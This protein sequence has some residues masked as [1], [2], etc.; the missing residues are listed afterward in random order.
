M[1]STRNLLCIA[2]L[3]LLA[4]TSS[5]AHAQTEVRVALVIGNGAY[6]HVPALPNPRNDSQKIAQKLTAIGFQVTEQ[7]NLTNEGFRRALRDFAR[8]A[9]GADM[10]LIYFAGHGIELNKFNYLIPVDAKLATDR[11]VEFEAIS[12]DMLM[13][14]ISDAKGLKMVLLDACRNNPFAAKMKTTGA[15][16]SIGRGLA[17]VE[18]ARGTLVS[19]A[20]KE[21]TT[22]A[23]GAGDHSPYTQALLDH[24]HQPGL[25][26]NFLFRKVRDA[27]IDATNGE[28]EPFTYG[29]LPG[30][31]VFLV[32]PAA[33]ASLPNGSSSDT[34]TDSQNNGADSSSQP[35]SG[36]DAAT[37]EWRLW[38]SVRNSGNSALLREYLT[39]YPKGRYAGIARV[40]IQQMQEQQKTASDNEPANDNAVQPTSADPFP[41]EQDI[42]P[43]NSFEHLDGYDAFGNDIRRY[44][45]V[46]LETCEAR[47]RSRSDCD[48]YTYNKRHRVCF[49]KSG[50]RFV[51]PNATAFTGS[52]A[53]S[54]RRRS[55]QAYDNFDFAGGDYRSIYGRNMIEC[56][57]ECESSSQC[58]G[59]AYVYKNKS[60][61]LKSHVGNFRRKRGVSLYVK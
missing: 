60:C 48:A 4:F 35:R 16:R 43:V 40:M 59:F 36:S 27:V 13:H 5:A 44:N 61:W 52:R 19:Y 34:G 54:V 46:S 45:R 10:A 55:M 32:P 33:Q 47:C 26:I 9:N 25:E 8:L 38:E 51:I 20:A 29:S 56:Y 42:R 1:A 58:A 17:R 7:E 30:K 15:K 11:D 49:L 22:A 57:N 23:D 39:T 50:A 6:S 37:E 28:Q 31:Q 14:S 12:L 41:T 2:L 18:P 21:G 3:A 53:A 24:L